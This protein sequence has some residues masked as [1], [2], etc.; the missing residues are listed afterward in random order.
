VRWLATPKHLVA[1]V[2]AQGEVNLQCDHRGLE[3]A[4]TQFLVGRGTIQGAGE[5]LRAELKAIED[6][7]PSVVLIPRR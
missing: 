5:R 2:D 3:V 1:V 7:G 6:D 4:G